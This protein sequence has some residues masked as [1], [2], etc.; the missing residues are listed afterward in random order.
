MITSTFLHISWIPSLSWDW[1]CSI[2]VVFCN[3][4]TKRLLIEAKDVVEIKSQ[5]ILLIIKSIRMHIKSFSLS[6]T[7][8]PNSLKWLSHI[9]TPLISTIAFPQNLSSRSSLLL[10]CSFP[11]NNTLIYIMRVALTVLCFKFRR[12]NDTTNQSFGNKPSG[13]LFILLRLPSNKLWYEIW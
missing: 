12:A 2:T 9:S 4:S 8:Q 7:L 10:H 13:F 11:A 3:S 6:A 5:Q 1:N